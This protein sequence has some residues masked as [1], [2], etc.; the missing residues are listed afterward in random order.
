[1]EKEEEMKETDKFFGKQ[2]T[3]LTK[4]DFLFYYQKAYKKGN[5]DAMNELFDRFPE[6]AEEVLC[7]YLFK[8]DNY[9]DYNS[10]I[11]TEVRVL[12]M[13]GYLLGKQQVPEKYRK[14]LRE[15]IKYQKNFNKKTFRYHKVYVKED[16]WK[17][18]FLF[19][20]ELKK[21]ISIRKIDSIEVLLYYT[22]EYN[23]K[24]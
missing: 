8:L 6:I 16:L 23:E 3:K 9:L 14:I 2:N 13:V 24:A 17:N 22:I 20:E 10:D 18:Y 11:I 5:L 1:M 19:C 7:D 4:E 15:T 21:A 12:Y